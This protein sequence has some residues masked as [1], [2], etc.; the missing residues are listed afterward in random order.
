MYTDHYW[1]GYSDLKDVQVYC[2][3]IVAE[4]TMCARFTCKGKAKRR[5]AS[6]LNGLCLEVA[7]PGSVII[8]F[9]RYC[10]CIARCTIRI[11]LWNCCLESLIQNLLGPDMELWII[12]RL[13]RLNPNFSWIEVM[14][15]SNM[16]F[17]RLFLCVFCRMVVCKQVT[18]CLKLMGKVSLASL[19]KSR[20]IQ[21][22]V[23]TLA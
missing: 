17:D 5:G 14:K 16:I 2:L 11:R 6:M 10:M 15:F 22:Y 21:P 8:S 7:L 1:A 4:V 19:R 18:S 20:F 12:L 13:S 3:S 23:I 9:Y